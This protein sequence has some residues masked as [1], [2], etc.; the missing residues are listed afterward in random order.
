MGALAVRTPA[1]AKRAVSVEPAD[2]SELADEERPR[3]IRI[4]IG[5][6]A[7]LVIVLALI[8]RECRSETHLQGKPE[9]RR[10]VIGD[11]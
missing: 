9:S 8:L 11:N 7:I 5:P 2:T 10:K 1:P 3:T 4:P 6:I